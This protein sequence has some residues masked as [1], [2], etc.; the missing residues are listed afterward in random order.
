MKRIRFL[1]LILL[2]LLVPAAALGETAEDITAGCSFV[3]SKVP[4]R[5]EL[6]LDDDYTTTWYTTAPDGVYIEVAAPEEQ[7]MGGVYIKWNLHAS[8]YYID[9]EKDGRWETVMAQP[10][11]GYAV[12]YVQ[13]PQDT[14]RF[15]LY[16]AQD[17]QTEFRIA[18]MRI[19]SPGE[20][21]DAVQLWEPVLDRCDI[22]IVTAHA[23]DEYLYMGGTIP[24]YV[25]QGKAVQVLYVSPSSSYRYLE[26]LDGLWSCGV[27]NY[28]I[29]GKFPDKHFFELNEIYSWWSQDALRQFLVSHFR[30]CKPSVIISHDLNGEYGH[31]AHIATARNTIWAFDNA[32][33][34]AYDPD[35]AEQYGVWQV[36]KLYLHL[37]QHNQ[38]VMDWSEPLPFFGGDNA[39]EIARQAY[40]LHRSQQ[41]T[42]YHVLDY[43]P[44]DCRKFGLYRTTVGED[45]QQN[46]FL[47]N[48]P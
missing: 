28:P 39:L 16:R 46:D 24:Y 4:S 23:D 29:L 22:M 35:S 21:P 34:P 45:I 38:I 40:A 43:G 14:K 31:A 5:A 30:M 42:N 37:Y 19:Y 18:E 2:L 13:L 7:T 1:F 9:V 8:A 48:I 11:G 27:H 41:V 32:A 15:R 17:D 26:L 33:D 36:Q 10:E 44:Y 20:R 12:E 47:E 6:M 25:A 3:P